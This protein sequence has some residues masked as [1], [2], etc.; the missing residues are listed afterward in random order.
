M[1]LPESEM[2]TT[3]SG[4]R[5][6]LRATGTCNELLAGVGH[7]GSGEWIININKWW[8]KAYH[9]GGVIGKITLEVQ[10]VLVIDG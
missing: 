5:R 4:D 2:W 9:H 10:F 3:G 1:K 7:V 8:L 6:G